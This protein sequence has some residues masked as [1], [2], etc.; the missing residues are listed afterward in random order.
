MKSFCVAILLLWTISTHAQSFQREINEQ[1]WK[2]FI[3]AYNESDPEAF[4]AV[5]SHDVVRAIRDDGRVLGYD[6]YSK[7]M[8]SGTHNTKVNRFQHKIELRFTETWVNHDL[9]YEVGI[10]KSQTI[11]PSGNNTVSFGRFHVVLRQEKGVWKILVDSDSSE[12]GTL[13]EKD[14]LAARPME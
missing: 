9:A 14:F 5:H 4:M 7:V 11:K 3:A 6:E 8:A 12:G 1:V 2:P 10:Y 13:T